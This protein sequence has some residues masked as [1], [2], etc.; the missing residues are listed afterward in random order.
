MSISLEENIRWIVFCFMYGFSRIRNSKANHVVFCFACYFTG[1]RTESS[2]LKTHLKSQEKVL[3]Q[4]MQQIKELEERERAA[5]ESVLY[6]P[7]FMLCLKL[8]QYECI[9]YIKITGC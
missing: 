2:L 6:F 4:R 7:Y 1:L 3:G 5:N 8:F 9:R